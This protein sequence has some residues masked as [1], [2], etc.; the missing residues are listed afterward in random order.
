MGTSYST[1]LKKA[2]KIPGVDYTW[3]TSCH[4]IQGISNTPSHLMLS[5]NLDKLQ[6]YG[7]FRFDVIKAAVSQF[8]PVHLPLLQVAGNCEVNPR[9]LN[10]F[11]AFK[12][13]IFMTVF[14][15]EEQQDSNDKKCSINSTWILQWLA[16][17]Y[18]LVKYYYCP[19]LLHFSDTLLVGL[20]VILQW[21]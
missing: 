13:N 5:S 9:L 12:S 2:R 8:L 15:W 19:K 11:L 7:I 4:T 14:D 10:C 6:Q 16:L 21:W 20:L 18:L 17:L 3:I 1:R